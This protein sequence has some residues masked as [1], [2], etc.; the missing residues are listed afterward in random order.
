MI[1]GAQ[2]TLRPACE[3]DRHAVYDWLAQS[4][5]TPS[6]MGPPTYT[7]APIPTWEEFCA[8]YVIGLMEFIMRP[9]ARNVRAIKAY[10]K[11]GFV[12]L[13]L[14]TTEQA[15]ICGET[16]HHDTI[17]MRKTLTTP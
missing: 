15:A 10:A 2:V 11:A 7:E 1:R 8:D 16:E 12:R 4:E 5:I 3:S 9:S 6:M 17:V 13:P 14:T